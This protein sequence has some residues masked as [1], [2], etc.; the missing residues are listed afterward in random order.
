VLVV[1]AG[2][3]AVKAALLGPGGATPAS[4]SVEQP[5]QHPGPER[6]EQRPDD[7]GLAFLTAVRGCRAAGASPVALAVT[8]QMQDL[9]PLDRH[10]RPTR[11]ALLYSDLRAS[12]ELGMLA[13]LP[14]VHAAGDAA[15]VTAGLIGAIPRAI[16]VSL[17]TSGWVAALTGRRSGPNEAIHHLVGPAGRESLL[18]GALLS[19]GATVE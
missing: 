9:V 17:G 14:L 4:V 3:T 13:G 19:A 2:T 1:D 15:S 7:W 18:I 11:P 12:A 16:S 6:V 10:G 8:G 5:V